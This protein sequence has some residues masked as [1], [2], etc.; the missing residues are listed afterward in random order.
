MLMQAIENGGSADR[1]TIK[2]AMYEMKDFVA[3]L[4]TLATDEN[5]CLVHETSIIQAQ[6]QEDG[7]CIFI[8][9]EKLKESGY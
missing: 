4:G 9:V 7:K 8:L 6:K 1:E 3:P 5:G 2:N